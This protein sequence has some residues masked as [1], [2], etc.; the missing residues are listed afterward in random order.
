MHNKHLLLAVEKTKIKKNR[1]CKAQFF[2]HSLTNVTNS[3]RL[4]GR[5]SRTFAYVATR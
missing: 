2:K 1:P 4:V 5:P 3:N